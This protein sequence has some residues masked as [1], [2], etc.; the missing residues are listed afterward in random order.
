M[1]KRIVVDP[2]TRIEGHL[3]IEAIIDENN[4]VLVSVNSKN[5]EI[6]SRLQTQFQD[7]LQNE[8]EKYNNSHWV[9]NS[10]DFSLTDEEITQIRNS[11]LLQK[12]SIAKVSL[13]IWFSI[14]LSLLV[15]LD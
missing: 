9:F 2:I 3:R 7:K 8:L 1:S 10:N 6:K 12:Y 5:E 14:V 15:N 11:G 4:V 13:A